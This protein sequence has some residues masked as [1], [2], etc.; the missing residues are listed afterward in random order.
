M[1]TVK[2]TAML[3]SFVGRYHHFGGNCCIR[4]RIVTNC[5]TFLYL[6]AIHMNVSSV[7]VMVKLSLCLIK[8][9]AIKLY[10]GSGSLAP[11]F[12][13]LGGGEWSINFTPWPL[14]PQGKSPWYPLDRKP[15]GPQS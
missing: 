11:L 9:Y 13:A 15:G 3:C 7:K 4:I 8:H 10:G 14:Y 2:Y 6:K 5:I 1:A 12:L